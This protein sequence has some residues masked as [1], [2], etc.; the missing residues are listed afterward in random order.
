MLVYH[1]DELLPLRYTNSDFQY[2][3]D[4]LKSTSDF[5]FTLSSGVVS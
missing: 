4:Y 1:Y 5:V 3:K 2:D